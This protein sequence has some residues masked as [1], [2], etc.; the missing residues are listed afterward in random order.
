MN[1]DVHTFQQRR[2][3]LNGVAHHR[4][5]YVVWVIVAREYA[6]D[7]HSIGLSNGKQFVYCV[8]RVYEE[9]LFR[10]GVTNQIGKIDHLMRDRVLGA[11]IPSTK[12][13]A[14]IERIVILSTHTQQN[15]TMTSNE[16]LQAGDLV[17]IGRHRTVISSEFADSLE[18]G[19]QVLALSH[20]GQLRRLPKAVVS[21]VDEAVSSASRA[22]TQLSDVSDSAINRFFAL[23]AEALQDDGRFSKVRDAN[24][25][26]EES[27]RE[28]G[29]SVTRLVLS[30]NMRRDM[31][32]ALLMW[33]DAPMSRDSV[34]NRTQHVGWSVEQRA[35][36]LGVLGFVFEGRP[37]VF[38][39]ATGVLK[40][41]NAVVF[42]IGSDALGTANAM[43]DVI[44][45]PSLIEAG[46]PVDAVVLLNSAEHAAGWSLFSD[47]RLGLAV[48]RGSGA[49][50][51]E[52]GS[53][54]QQS[55]VP[56]SLHGTGG[57]WMIVGEEAS[58]DRLESCVLHS[59]DRKVCN[60]LNVVAVIRHHASVHIPIILNAAENAAAARGTRPRIHAIQGAEEFL[61]KDMHIV[62]RRSEGEMT[63]SQT[64]VAS[65]DSLGREYEWEEN[66]EFAI[67]L[68]NDLG[69]AVELFNA[70]SPQ[71]IVSMISEDSVE[72]QRIWSSTN[73]PFFGDGFTRWVDGQF[74]LLRPELGLSNWENGRLFG[75]SGIL[76][77]DSAFTVRLRVQQT[78][79]KLHR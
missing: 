11:E 3:T 12:K 45:R 7:L 47:S 66:P 63:E 49:A 77:G 59:L 61:P 41:G 74:S 2:D 68:V 32:A 52:L 13:L 36:P 46:L 73:A 4:A 38:A 30:E 75:R 26:D 51:S 53:I 72:Q 71:F 58:A 17:A 16:L 21:L 15:R 6:S 44:I 27:A 78:D 14:K 57:A 5:T 35:A 10:I 28:R 48:A 55:G 65:V 50:V 69:E 54:A 25:R 31:I 56:V 34:M 29:R 23:A 76:S 42:R 60:T 9:A 39:D 79:D 37:N 40:G 64:T 8:R 20:N 62:V 1:G 43:M 22:F 67:V 70:Y 33:R 19:D 18:P 24:Q